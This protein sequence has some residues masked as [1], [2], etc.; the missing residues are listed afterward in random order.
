MMGG[1]FYDKHIGNI[2][3]DHEKILNLALNNLK[4]QLGFDLQP[5]AQEISILKVKKENA[6]DAILTQILFK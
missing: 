5:K 3:N 4:K 2:E 6:F 1:A